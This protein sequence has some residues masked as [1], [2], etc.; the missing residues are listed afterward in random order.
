MPASPTSIIKSKIAALLDSEERI[1]TRQ[2]IKAYITSNDPNGHSY[3]NGMFNGALRS[4]YSNSSVYEKVG[5]GEYRRIPNPPGSPLSRALLV[6]T[7][8]RDKLLAPIPTRM[9]ELGPNDYL[10]A[11]LVRGCIAFLDEQIAKLHS[12]EE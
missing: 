6:L 3:T 7:Q 8:T 5:L 2:E 10:V 9:T 1:F 11:E 4:L 12:M